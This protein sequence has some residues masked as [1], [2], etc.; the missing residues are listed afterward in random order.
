MLK[1]IDNLSLDKDPC[2]LGYHPCNVDATCTV[3][4]GTQPVCTCSPC[5]TGDGTACS[6]T[7]CPSGNMEC[8]P[9]TG[10]CECGEDFSASAG[11]DHCTRIGTEF[12]KLSHCVCSTLSWAN[13]HSVSEVFTNLTR[14]VSK[15]STSSYACVATYVCTCSVLGWS[16]RTWRDSQSV[17]RCSLKWPHITSPCRLRSTE[18]LTSSRAWWPV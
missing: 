11:D 8:R 12:L 9:L 17:Q 15:H 5:Y 18:L 13:I 7:M 10:K 14:D 16:R 6:K 1:T 4:N 3:V 2:E